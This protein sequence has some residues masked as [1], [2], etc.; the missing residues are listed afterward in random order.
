[1]PS[2]QKGYQFRLVGV[3]GTQFCKMHVLRKEI[4]HNLLHVHD[5][6]HCDY[7]EFPE[8][9]IDHYRLGVRI[10]D[11]PY[12]R[13]PLAE[14]VKLVLELAPEICALQIVYGPLE[15]VLLA[16]GCKTSALGTHM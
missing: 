12:S 3:T 6:C 5:L 16:V 8:M 7:G 15:T 4:I 13:S 11:H 9:G 2:T 1:M 14:L 10:A